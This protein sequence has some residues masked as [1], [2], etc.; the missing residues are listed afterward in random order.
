MNISSLFHRAAPTP[1][2]LE[3][4]GTQVRAVQFLRRGGQLS[5][6]ASASFAVHSEES[7]VD[8]AI[9]ISNVLRRRGFHSH[10]VSLCV[11]LPLLESDLLPLACEASSHHAN[12]S[13]VA[14]HFSRSARCSASDI[15]VAWWSRSRSPNA[16]LPSYAVA[17]RHADAIRLVSPFIEAGFDVVCLA[18]PA[19]A[20]SPL[21]PI[22]PLV[23]T[24]TK[25]APSRNATCLPPCT[26]VL[27]LG[28]DTHLTLITH[29]PSVIYQRTLD[30]PG[31]RHTPLHSDMIDPSSLSPSALRKHLES[32]CDEFSSTLGC[33]PRTFGHLDVERVFLSGPFSHHPLLLD[34]AR[35]HLPELQPLL[36]P[37]APDFAFDFNPAFD[38][39][40]GL[41]LLSDGGG[42]L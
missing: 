25:S 24:S 13:V 21:L 8:A 2:G 42:H 3:I 28:L 41:A 29:G 37:L 14:A 31:L 1:I 39:A 40:S 36:F 11:P 7:P 23:P 18:C 16:S 6:L 9:T 20:I 32:A 19:A 35:S 27:R 22:S 30:T 12:A 34:T 4:D 5:Q 10:L 15:E 38:L 33:V 26:A 17:L